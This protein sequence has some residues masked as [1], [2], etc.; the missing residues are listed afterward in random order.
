MSSFA[1]QA[2]TIINNNN[3]AVFIISCDAIILSCNEI[4]A[5]IFKFKNTESMCGKHVKSLVPSEFSTYFPNTISEEHLTKGVYLPRVNK[6]NDGNL[7]ASEILT[8]YKTIEGEK[9]IIVHLKECKTPHNIYILCMQ[10][11]IEILKCE[12]A[13]EKRNNKHKKINLKQLSVK[14]EAL[15]SKDIYFCELLTQGLSSHQIARKLNITLDG[16]FAA[17]KRIRKKLKLNQKQELITSIV[18]LAE[19]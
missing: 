9:Y 4:A 17:R 10:Q 8:Y 13:K 1:K 11:N 2:F 14:H 18:K 16:V 7:F 6:R 15:T 19:L 12:L 3:E 5:K